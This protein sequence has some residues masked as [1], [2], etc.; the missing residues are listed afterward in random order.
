MKKLDRRTF[1]SQT[2]LAGMGLTI[3][4]SHVLGGVGRTAPSDKINVALIG[5][6]T[7]ALKMLPGWLEREEL[8]L[9]AVCDPNKES[10]DYPLWGQPK[11]EK[12]GAPGGDCP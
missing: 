6:G 4:P 1:I 2:S 10:Y 5:A 8:Q 11:G 9:V 7:Q 3:V 12:I